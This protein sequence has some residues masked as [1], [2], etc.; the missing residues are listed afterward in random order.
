MGESEVRIII[1]KVFSHSTLGFAYAEIYASSG[2]F[3]LATESLGV[4]PAAQRM[5]T[6]VARI[7]VAVTY[8]AP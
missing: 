1:D 8:P 6:D 5:Q 7:V 4:F 3:I 2:Q